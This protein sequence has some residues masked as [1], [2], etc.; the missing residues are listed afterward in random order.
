MFQQFASNVVG[1][2]GPDAQLDNDMASRSTRPGAFMR[3]MLRP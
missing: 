1:F 2:R 3:S